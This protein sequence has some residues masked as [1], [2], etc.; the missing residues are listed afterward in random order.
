M[1]WRWLLVSCSWVLHELQAAIG[2]VSDQ[3]PVLDYT[4][5]L[6]Q[7][8]VLAHLKHCYKETAWRILMSM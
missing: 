1:A 5:V 7:A 3:S 2:H 6:D 8:P 4:P